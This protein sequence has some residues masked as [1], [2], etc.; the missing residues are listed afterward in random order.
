[1]H[2]RYVK[3]T[4]LVII[5]VFEEVLVVEKRLL[6]REEVH[7]SKRTARSNVP[8]TVVLR[9]EVVDIERLEADESTDPH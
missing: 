8:Q 4:V 1:M 3:R 7:L 5:P 9:H 2:P 6:L